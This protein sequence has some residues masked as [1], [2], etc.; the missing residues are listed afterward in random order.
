[1][2]PAQW[3]GLIFN[4]RAAR[5]RGNLLLGRRSVT[6]KLLLSLPF[7]VGLVWLRME[8]CSRFRHFLQDLIVELEAQLRGWHVRHW[9]QDLALSDRSPCNLQ[10]QSQARRMTKSHKVLTG[11]PVL[12]LRLPGLDWVHFSMLK[13][14]C[15]L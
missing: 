9:D 7:V 2:I 1:M 14:K 4:G 3:W 11:Q 15:N 12:R 13:C 8:T 10:H 5:P 6:K